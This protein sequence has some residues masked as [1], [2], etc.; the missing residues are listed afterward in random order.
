MSITENWSPARK[1][2]SGGQTRIKICELHLPTIRRARLND[3]VGQV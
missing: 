3:V 2:H 1:I